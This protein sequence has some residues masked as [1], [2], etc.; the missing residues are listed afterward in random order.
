[1]DLLH[2]ILST[3]QPVTP[4]LSLPFTTL[5]SN[6][7]S[8][9]PYSV[10]LFI[11]Y[12]KDQFEAKR[13]R[14]KLMRAKRKTTEN[15][16][17]RILLDNSRTARVQP[18]FRFVSLRICFPKPAHPTIQLGTCSKYG[19]SNHFQKNSCFKVVIN[20]K[21]RGSGSWQVFEDGT[22][23]WRSMSVYFSI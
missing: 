3:S 11:I 23:P 18:P 19:F 7:S 16:E 12:R 1:M 22:R 17:S 9:Q 21:R 6:Q 20:E 2:F 5:F 15:M 8:L 4:P 14:T 13:K 10:L